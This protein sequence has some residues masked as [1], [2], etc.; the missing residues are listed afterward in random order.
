MAPA[1]RLTREARDGRARGPGPAGAAGLVAAS[2]A[3]MAGIVFVANPARYGL[4]GL[5]LGTVTVVAGA[6]AAVW[7]FRAAR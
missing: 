3:V 7:I 4:S 5:L 6:A 1:A 2:V